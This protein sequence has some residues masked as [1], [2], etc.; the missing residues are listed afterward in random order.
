MNKPKHPPHHAA[1]SPSLLRTRILLVEDHPMMRQALKET[2]AQEPDLIV[3]G[4]AADEA[5]AMKLLQST[6]PHL[7]LMDLSLGEG[8]GLELTKWI[9]KTDPTARVLVLSMHDELLYAERAIHAGARG[10]INKRADPDTIVAAIRTVL[11]GEVYLNPAIVGR[12][13]QRLAGGS[14]DAGAASVERLSDREMQTFELIGAGLGSRDIAERLCVSVKTIEAYRQ[15]IKD[16]LGIGT[17][18]ELA[19][20]AVEWVLSK[21]CPP[22]KNNNPRHYLI[23][24]YQ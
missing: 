3:C 24:T 8:S 16:K 23:I 11:N 15:R 6:S 13:L 19:R 1:A 17:G 4:E 22:L 21:A 12:I 18:P 9:V 2:L 7:V 20:R 14:A 10:Y 5:A